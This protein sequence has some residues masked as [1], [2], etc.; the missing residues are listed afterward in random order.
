MD[1]KEHLIQ[2]QQQLIESLTNEIQLLRA[3]MSKANE[4]HQAEIQRL[5]GQIANLTETLQKFVGRQ[6]ASSSEKSAHRQIHGQL[7]LG[8]FNEVEYLTDQS[9]DANDDI[10]ELPKKKQSRKSRSK[11]EDLYCNLPVIE[12]VYAISEENQSCD[13]CKSHMTTIGKEYVR[14][15]IRIVPAKIERIHIYRE[16]YICN[17]CKEDEYI[18]IKKAKAPAP[19][20]KHSEASPSIVAHIMYQKYHNALPLNRQEKD[21]KRLGIELSRSKQAWWVNNAA[22]KYFEPIT[23]LLHAELILRD[24]VMSDETKCQVHREEGRK[25]TSD[26]FMWI[27]RSGN[28]GLPP[29]INYEYQETRHGAHAVTYLDGFTGYHQCDGYQGYNKL[30]NVTRIACLA[31]IRRKFVEAIPKK[32]TS[33]TLTPAEEGALY[34]NKLF[35]LERDFKTL[36]SKERYIKR[37]ELSKPV[38]EAFW[39]WLDK[40]NPPGGSNLYKAVNYARNQKEYMMNFLLDGRIEISNNLTENSVRPYTLLRK[41]SL[42]HDTPKGATASAIICSLMETAKANGLDVQKYLE[43]LLH[44]MPDRL[45]ESADAKDLLPWSKLAQSQC[46]IKSK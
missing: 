1:F 11:R 21:F 3:E 9:P 35:E 7:D 12:E 32:K 8:L 14:E 5:M 26:S 16:S 15:E 19:L 18:E 22:M 27:H 4:V 39:S 33:D 34:C 20:F 23:T 37:L 17:E 28:D 46:K 10:E 30:K 41:N 40:Q 36:E 13:H 38:L 29:I 24:I 44:E 45:T 2:N 6:F 31:H 25:N 42:F 43:F